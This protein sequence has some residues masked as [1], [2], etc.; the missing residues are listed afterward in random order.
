MQAKN[1]LSEKAY[2]VLKKKMATE[3][4][5]VKIRKSQLAITDIQTAMDNLKK[6]FF[7]I[8]KNQPDVP[9]TESICPACKQDIPA[10]Q[11]EE[12]HQKHIAAFN[13]SKAK[14]LMDINKKGRELT[15]EKEQ[16]ETL[17]VKYRTELVQTDKE[18]SVLTS[19]NNELSKRIST[20]EKDIEN[21]SYPNEY[22][23][24]TK[25]AITLEAELE[26]NQDNSQ[27]R[28]QELQMLI[29]TNRQAIAEMTETLA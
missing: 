12:A 14:T 5:E 8:Q 4:L 23:E 20:M 16:Q 9:E 11:I 27:E 19:E 7:K 17:F 15:A 21:P 18:L 1:E 3:S 28:I 6:E 2:E 24:I 10:W 22:H 26:N 25:Q 13:A 29:G